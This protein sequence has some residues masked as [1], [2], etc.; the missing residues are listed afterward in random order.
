VAGEARNREASGR[1][2]TAPGALFIESSLVMMAGRVVEISLLMTGST[3]T[4]SSAAL[5]QG[6]CRRN[7]LTSTL[8][9]DTL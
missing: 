9:G 4:R 7:G 3:L 8:L 6:P 1:T 5:D 2:T